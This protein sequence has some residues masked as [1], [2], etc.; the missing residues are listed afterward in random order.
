[1]ET[2]ERYLDEHNGKLFTSTFRIDKIYKN[3]D[4][5]AKYEQLLGFRNE[6]KPIFMRVSCI[7]GDKSYNSNYKAC[8]MYVETITLDGHSY[9]QCITQGAYFTLLKELELTNLD[10]NNYSLQN[11]LRLYLNSK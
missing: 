8:N 3:L 10:H 7:I 1:M 5:L 11:W 9:G 2:R 4:K 6:F